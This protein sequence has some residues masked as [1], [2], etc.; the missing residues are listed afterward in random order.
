[1]YEG[2]HFQAHKLTE[3]IHDIDLDALDGKTVSK[4]SFYDYVHML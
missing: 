4:V 3:R 2:V 1:M